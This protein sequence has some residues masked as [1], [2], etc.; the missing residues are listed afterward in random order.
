MFLNYLKLSLRQLVGNPFFS[1]I[2]IVGLAIGFAA[3]Y[4]LWEFSTSE[5]KADQY[6]KDYDRIAR[7]GLNWRWTDDGGKTW[8][9]IKG[10]AQPVYLP[11]PALIDNPDIEAFVQIMNQPQFTESKIGHGNQVIILIQ[12]SQNQ[13]IVFKEEKAVYACANLFSFFSIPLIY[14]Q[15]DKVLNEAGFVVLSHSTAV[16]YFG[17]KDPTG[18]LL[19]LND[20]ITLKVSGVYADLPHNT[21]LYFDL[22]IANQGFLNQWNSRDGWAWANWYVKLREGSQFA[23]LESELNKKVNEYFA[24]I[25]RQ[26]PQAKLDFFVQPLSEVAFSQSYNFDNFYPKSRTFLFTLAFIALSVLL[27]ALVNYVNLTVTRTTRRLR[28]VATRKVSGAGV[29]D[30]VKQFITEAAVVN[31]LALVLALTLIQLM[32]TPMSVL[33]NIHIASLLSLSSLTLFIFLG[34]T[35]TGILLSGLYPALISN[36]YHPR[37]LFRISYTSSG[38]RIIPSLL[39]ISQFAAALVF[40]LF[41]FV[42]SL[43]LNHILKKETGIKKDE[44]L[45]VDGPIV[46]SK[47]SNRDFEELKKQISRQPAVSAVSS[48]NVVIGDRWDDPLVS[49]RVGADLFFGMDNAGVDENFIPFYEL[50]L[51][52]GRNF[53]PDDRADVVILSRFAALR[54]GFEKPEGAVGLTVNLAKG[55]EMKWVNAEVIGIVE[56]FRVVSLLNM[57]ESSTEYS[58]Q[59]RG[60]VLLNQDKLFQRLE[61]QRIGLKISSTKIEETISEIES[62]YRLQFPGNAFNWYFLDEHANLAYGNEKIARNQIILFTGLAIAIA[63]MGLL[64]MISYKAVE[65][66]KE[67]GV[68][69]VLGAKTI[70]IGSLLLNA[71]LK[72]IMISVVIG[73]PIAYYLIQQYFKK[74]SEH[75]VLQWWHYALPIVILLFIM[76]A[77]IASVL[78]KAARS[79]P[80]EA[81]KYE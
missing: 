7:I 14:G 48:S 71:T 45:I 26:F 40:I 44:I 1:S 25:L 63:C 23:L 53:L 37:A 54:L 66:T 64:G 28:E 72:Q 34:I 29:W 69:K 42:V 38:K 59:G 55:S 70:H 50:R 39:T 2:N 4:T 16:K 33:F 13:H 10:G 15:P 61:P 19:G 51:I 75:V 60:I 67:I 31:G 17:E 74:F 24:E 73:V 68:R 18:E 46:K 27:M 32:R 80:V 57:N 12:N 21:H 49:R 52:N 65:K 47:N 58:D 43:Q 3:F 8:G 9:H 36:A 5:L 62:L 11:G 22:V 77:T 56:D 79:N 78:Y 30:M 41:G 81:L 35:L 20:T 76:L 6:H